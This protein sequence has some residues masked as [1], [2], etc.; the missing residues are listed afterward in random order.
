MT[1][2]T[3]NDIEFLRKLK[4]HINAS[5]LEILTLSI[6]EVWMGHD[7]DYRTELTIKLMRKEKSK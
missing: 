1:E 6:D 2:L 3:D 7:H 5:E 4:E